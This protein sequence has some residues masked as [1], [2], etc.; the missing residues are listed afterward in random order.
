MS[1]MGE[2]SYKTPGL[3]EGEAKRRLEK[4]GLNQSAKPHQIYFFGILKEEITEPMILLLLSVGII[5]SLWGKLED[6]LTIFSIIIALVLVEVWNEYRAKKA[7]AALSKLAAPKTRVIRESNV[8]EI[9]TELI[10][11]GDVL[12]LNSGTRIS[13]DARL[14]TA[15]SLQ[16]DESSLTGESLSVTKSAGDEIYAGTLIVNGEGKAEV[17]ATGLATRFGKISSL[18]QSIK[19]PKTPLQ[20]AM[21]KLAKGLVWAALFFSVTIP[22]LGVLR[23]EDLRQMIL[24]GLAL[25]FA[26][27]PEE[28]PIIITMILGLGA[29]Q[30]SKKDFLIKKIKAAEVLGDATVILTDK[31]GTLTENV[32]HVVSVYPGEKEKDVVQSAAALLTEMS[33]FATDKAVMQKAQELKL[34]IGQGDIVKERGF[35]NGRKTRA[36]L[37]IINGKLQLFVSGA[38]E[39][40]FDLVTGNVS[41]YQQELDAETSKGRRVIAVATR[42]ISFSEQDEDF[43]LL[44]KDLTMLGLISIEDPARKGVK[45]TLELAQKAGI[46]TIMVTGD[47][48]QTALFIAQNVGIPADSA[49]TGDEL[50][51]I[52]DEELRK[53]VKE[54]SVFAR[55]TPEH[56][57][58]L[59]KALQENGEIVAVTG[60]GVND[61]LALKG[62]NI[63]IAM[64][65]KGTDAAKEAAD[66]VL[67]D[68][69]YSTIAHAIFEGRKFHDNLRKG[70][71]Y[72]L[73]VKTALILIFALPV[74]IGIPFPF[75][76]VQI[77][78]L[79]LFM[80]L[81]ASSGFVAEPAEKSIYQRSPGNPGQKFL[82]T[83]MLKNIALSGGSLFAAVIIPYLYALW[84]QIPVT[85]AQTIAFSAWIIG[86]V[87]LA[88]VSRSE[89]EPLYSIGVF[90]NKIITLWAFCAFVF[91]LLSIT[92]P[93]IGI[94]LK[95]SPISLNQLGLI[96][97]VVLLTISWKEIIKI[98]SY[99]RKQPQSGFPDK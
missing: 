21:K 17:T 58:R 70:F 13:A 43:S 77:I 50:D 62:A 1:N 12:V 69:N 68:D 93:S 71:G 54:V 49:L 53:V 59:L 40:I 25:A 86:H 76:P 65:I 27:I 28:G 57:Y 91:L 3:S 83:N 20:I 88:F 2:T 8:Q 10:V 29:Y 60:D 90:S 24:T 97:I 87:I 11:P 74:I 48:P 18:A 6:T 56:K 55:S 94:P 23:G 52:S 78:L 39:E 75:A 45:Q 99:S 63:G 33:L 19:Q 15:L 42:T 64:G 9:E 14:I 80:D 16:V 47:H 92:V 61:T 46:R 38:P 89:N 96:F 73:S 84:Q 72:Y 41:A 79:E 67:A 36:I 30:L 31:T 81:A 85:Q 37:R 98:I 5:Y 22:M 32:M 35:G 34:E 82:D 7:I 51:P 44:E 4:F 26:T 66:V 95:L